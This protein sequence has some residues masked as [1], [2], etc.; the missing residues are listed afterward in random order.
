MAQAAGADSNTLIKAGATTPLCSYYSWQ[1][2]TD[3]V[4]AFI[5]SHPNTAPSLCPY[6]LC[7]AV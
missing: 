7:S 2:L 4:P 1:V 5:T 3:V 6:T